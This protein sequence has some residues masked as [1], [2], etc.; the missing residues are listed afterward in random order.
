MIIGLMKQKL[1]KINK[2]FFFLLIF[3]SLTSCENEKPNILWITVEDISPDLG[4][5]GD[6]NANTPVLD[7]LASEGFMYTNAFANA[8]VCAPARSAIIT[9]MYPS[10][11]GSLHMRSYAQS[12]SESGE[13]PEE[14]LFF[15]EI[16][17]NNGYYCTN[18]DCTNN[19]DE[20]HY[21]LFPLYG[22][23]PESRKIADKTNLTTTLSNDG[24]QYGIQYNKFVPILVKAIQEL[25]AE[26]EI[27][28][29]K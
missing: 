7:K 18:N 21:N 23:I 5:Y 11:I 24:K 26:I 16:F 27:L 25:S 19:C 22:Y 10:S 1:I 2:I 14:F 28:K 15:P 13:L 20:E 8:P 4:C 9:G 29:A 3:L 6:E 12:I 17:R